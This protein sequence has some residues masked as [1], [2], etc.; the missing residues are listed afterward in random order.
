MPFKTSFERNIE[1]NNLRSEYDAKIKRLND[2]YI[3]L[4]H[5]YD[6]VL[7]Y[8]KNYEEWVDIRKKNKRVYQDLK[9]TRKTEKEKAEKDRAK[10][11][12]LEKISSD[13]EIEYNNLKEEYINLKQLDDELKEQYSNTIEKLALERRVNSKIED[14]Q[15]KEIEDLKLKIGE[16][17]N[18]ASSL[19]AVLEDYRTEGA[20]HI[21]QIQSLKE[22]NKSLKETITELRK[23]VQSWRNR[24]Y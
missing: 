11:L 4:K 8:K 1:L 2:K 5:E 20:K 22:T 18:K 24:E 21:I 14:R 10:C 23:E 13:K 3:S 19:E 9:K 16:F 12:E 7:K 6:N 17:N 15:K